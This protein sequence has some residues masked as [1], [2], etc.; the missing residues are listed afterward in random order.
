MQAAGEESSRDEGNER[1]GEGGMKPWLEYDPSFLDAGRAK[2][3]FDWLNTLPMKPETGDCTKPS[4]DDAIQR[5]P[6]Q[7]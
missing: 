5:R 2:A 4:T 3:I 1:E 6:R 7:A